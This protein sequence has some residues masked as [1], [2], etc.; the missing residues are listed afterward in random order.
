MSEPEEIRVQLARMEGKLD[1][2]NLRHDQHD[3]KFVATD[4]RLNSHG[5]RISGLEKREVARDGERKGISTA[6]R[7]LWAVIGLIGGAGIVALLK[8]A[9][10]L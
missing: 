9:L 4:T 6:G 5:E 1:M 7:W 2:S 10:G 8:T 3:G